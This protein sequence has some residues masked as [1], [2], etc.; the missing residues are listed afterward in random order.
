MG[1]KGEVIFSDGVQS[2]LELLYNMDRNLYFT[3]G[4][5]Y[6]VVPWADVSTMYMPLEDFIEAQKKAREEHLEKELEGCRKALAPKHQ[7]D[8]FTWTESI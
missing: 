1:I 3:D 8:G 4:T 7:A 6:L 5:S 2:R